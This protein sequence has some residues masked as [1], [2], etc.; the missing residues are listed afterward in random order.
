MEIPLTTKI[1]QNNEKTFKYFFDCIVWLLLKYDFPE[2]YDI[3]FIDDDE[4]GGIID[5][6][7]L[8]VDLTE[9]S[10]YLSFRWGQDAKNY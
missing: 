2:E 9:D 6:K 7:K 3:E 4:I 1:S 8:I 5:S 10:I